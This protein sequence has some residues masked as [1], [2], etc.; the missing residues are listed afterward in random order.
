[1]K[2]LV[3]GDKFR[4]GKSLPMWGVEGFTPGVD[5]GLYYTAVNIHKGNYETF[6]HKELE[7]L[8]DKLNIFRLEE[9]VIADQLGYI[10][11]DLTE[12]DKERLSLNI[13]SRQRSKP[14][15][16]DVQVGGSHYPKEGIQPIEYILANKLGFIEGCVVKY[17]TRFREKNGAEDLEKIKHY[18]DLLI[19]LEYKNK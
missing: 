15:A 8:G 7:S 4:I 2:N 6:T 16:L 19:E 1:M 3:I 13:D 14:S 11:I 18:I 9:E 5:G 12:E 17:I 10:P